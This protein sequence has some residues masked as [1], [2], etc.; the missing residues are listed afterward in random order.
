MRDFKNLEIGDWL[1]IFWYRKWYF[2][3][4]AVIVS[5]GAVG[6]AW[7]LPNFYKSE[8]RIQI[9]SATMPEEFVRSGAQVSPADRIWALREQFQGPTFLQG[10]VEQN[11]LFGYGTRE[12]FSMD[13]AVQT[14]RANHR[15]D[16]TLGNVFILSFTATD[17]QI[18]RD[19]NACLENALIQST[20]SARK[21][22]AVG[23]DQ[24]IEDQL[25]QT[26][27]DLTAQEEKIKAFKIAHLGELPEQ[28][29]ANIN[30]IA[31]QNT[32]L[33]AA[34][35]ALQLA[36]DQRRR[37]EF[38]QQEQGRLDILTRDVLP[39]TGVVPAADTGERVPDVSNALLETKKA[40]LA[41]LTQ[42]YKETHPDVKL[43]AREVQELE[44]RLADRKLPETTVRAASGQ[45]QNPPKP[46]NVA[47]AVGMAPF[48]VQDAEIKFELEAADNEIAKWQKERDRILQQLKT[49]QAKLY[50]APA[51]EQELASLMREQEVLRQ[52]YGNLQ[53]KRFNS[54]MAAKM[55]TDTR[56]EI[57]KIIDA[58]SLPKRPSFPD[59]NNIILMGLGAGILLGL[60]AAFMRD[61]LDRTLGDEAQAEHALK[62]PVLASISEVPAKGTPVKY[63]IPQKV[64]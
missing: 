20:R 48:N 16:Y 12:N 44:K 7:R 51:I 28:S 27:R 18:A 54:S 11:H 46:A 58:A 53:N 21:E 63:Q 25:R 43:L 57:F 52:Q 61:F 4:T 2:V 45:P 49:S 17:P 1:R 37:L 41:E 6:Y 10:I 23:T 35:N 59:R 56:N 14:L 24:F 38:R 15:I 31:A 30:A 40:Q 9:E 34:E 8:S 5:A 19:V 39:A 3:L 26:A 55:E 33:A 60:G 29:T 22:Q 32:Q 13:A 64:G 47:N 62:L 42:R 36:K 50:V